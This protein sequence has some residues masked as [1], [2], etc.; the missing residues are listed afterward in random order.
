[1]KEAVSAV[2]SGENR[3]DF[4][5]VSFHTPNV[6]SFV[7][8]LSEELEPCSSQHL[9]AKNYEYID[10]PL[11]LSHVNCPDLEVKIFSYWATFYQTPKQ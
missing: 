5:F 2:P 9:A 10:R 11:I 6:A 3:Y 1:M 7:W 8:C 4:Y